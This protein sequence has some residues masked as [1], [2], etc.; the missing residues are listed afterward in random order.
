MSKRYCLIG[1]II[2]F[3]TICLHASE[4]NIP[5]NVIEFLDSELLNAGLTQEQIN[6]INA[7][8]S[9]EYNQYID[10]A[11]ANIQE[12]IEIIKVAASLTGSFETLDKIL[13]IMGMQQ[14]HI[15][16]KELKYSA[17]TNI[18]HKLIMGANPGKFSHD[19]LYTN[20]TTE[21]IGFIINNLVFDILSNFL[22]QTKAGKWLK[23]NLYIN[24]MPKPAQ[25]IG[26]RIL[27]GLIAH[28]TWSGQKAIWLTSKTLK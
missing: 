5:I 1:A 11:R 18:I 26:K 4:K 3:S 24:T 15:I 16:L 19:R 14:A 7:V 17:R 25:W 22:N 20:A 8:A 23:E 2:V 28:L 10:T 13:K 27:I 12:D 6:K 9:K 21:S